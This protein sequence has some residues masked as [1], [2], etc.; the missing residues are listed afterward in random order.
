MIALYGFPEYQLPLFPDLPD[1]IFSPRAL[2]LLGELTALKA[3]HRAGYSAERTRLKK[4]GDILLTDERTGERIRVEVK[5]SRRHRD[6]SYR[7]CL[8][9]RTN[10]VCTDY[11]DSH[12]VVLLAVVGTNVVSFVIPCTDLDQSQVTITN[13]LQTRKYSPYRRDLGILEVQHG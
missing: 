9:R 7:F 8:Y 4:Q 5:T 6:G 11:R 12:F 1:P 2:G 3:F 10:R 13:L